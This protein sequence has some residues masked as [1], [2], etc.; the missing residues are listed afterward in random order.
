[1]HYAKSTAG[2]YNPAIHGANIPDDAVEITIEEYTALL[3]GQ[4]TGKIITPD[5]D[6][7]PRLIDPVP[8]SPTLIDYQSA[9][10]G[11]LDNKAR[12]RNYD[13][14]LSLCTYTTSG[15]QIFAAEGQAGVSWRDAAWAKCYE[16]LMEVAA[17]TRTQPTVA[18][19][20]TELPAM[21]W[22]T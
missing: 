8:L 18:E 14:I 13:G 12:E 9:V 2:F 5:D 21:D 6:G 22:P 7:Y 3:H 19:L 16:V 15:N 1:M 10:Q 4:S 11:R 20:L 17:G